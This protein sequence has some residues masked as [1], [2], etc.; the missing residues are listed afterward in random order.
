MSDEASIA[1]KS[2]AVM[3]EHERLIWERTIKPLVT[4]EIIREHRARPFGH[5]TQ[6]LATLLDHLRRDGE[7]DLPRYV[8]V[9][10]VPDR[11][12]LVGRHS[13]VRGRPIAILKDRVFT[14]EA[15]VE[16][17]IFLRRLQ[18]RGIVLPL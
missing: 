12:W 8:S 10:T 17:A 11:E 15:E 18:D 9:M 1:A 5:H 3:R 4:D 7:R 2:D 13:R 14:S 16:H 6:S